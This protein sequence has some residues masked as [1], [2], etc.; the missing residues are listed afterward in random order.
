MPSAPATKT[1]FWAHTG[2]VK[3]PPGKRCRHTS[4]IFFGI[5]AGTV[6]V[7][8]GLARNIGQ[9]SRAA[10]ALEAG[11]AHEGDA[12]GATHS[13]NADRGAMENVFG[14]NSER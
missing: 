2:A 5:A 4:R 7:P 13:F 11:A 1:R 6:A 3:P 8:A 12:A 14:I 9:S 10:G